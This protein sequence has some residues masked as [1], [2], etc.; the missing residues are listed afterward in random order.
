MWSLGSLFP[1]SPGNGLLCG[2]KLHSRQMGANK[3]A[4]SR[5]SAFNFICLT[6]L[7]L[8]DSGSH[9][10]GFSEALTTSF[11][12]GQVDSEQKNSFSSCPAG[13]T[14]SSV[15]FHLVQWSAR[16]NNRAKREGSGGKIARDSARSLTPTLRRTRTSVT[17]SLFPLFLCFSQQK[18]RRT[19]SLYLWPYLKRSF[20]AQDPET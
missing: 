7:A 6:P 4:I 5:G 9:H 13:S 1:H 3:S 15:D 10:M 8:Q 12:I 18:N 19:Y 17:Q 11:C 20:A 14:S 16:P 2:M